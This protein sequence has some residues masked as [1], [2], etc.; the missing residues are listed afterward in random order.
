ME[1][2]F[3]NGSGEL[4]NMWPVSVMITDDEADTLDGGTVPGALAGLP[5]GSAAYTCGWQK[6]WQLGTDGETW[7]VIVGG[8][9]SQPVQP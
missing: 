7:T 5:V 4:T 6:I 1:G 2:L 8:E 3:V 9:S